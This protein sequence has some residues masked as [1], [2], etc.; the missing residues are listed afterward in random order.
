MD[1]KCIDLQEYAEQEVQGK[2]DAAYLLQSHR[3]PRWVLRRKVEDQ[4]AQDRAAV[5]MLLRETKGEPK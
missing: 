4:E 2:I 5:E 3:E 1:D